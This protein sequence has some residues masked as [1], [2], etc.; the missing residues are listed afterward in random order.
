MIGETVTDMR[1]GFD[2]LSILAQDVL[3]QDPFSGA[4]FCFRGRRGDLVKI[5][6]LDGQG[7]CLFAKR[8]EKSRFTW[9]AT[10]DPQDEMLPIPLPPC[11]H[12]E[13]VW[14]RLTTQ[15]LSPQHS[16]ARAGS[17][18]GPSRTSPPTLGQARSW[19]VSGA[20]S[21]VT[22]DCY[23]APRC[24]PALPCNHRPPP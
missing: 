23:D 10:L 5:L 18:S 7:F 14:P 17:F 8:L 11:S 16:P 3:K 22:F 1:K 13:A 19:G 15:S 21:R 9:P 24:T 2:G 4:I 6:Y 20:T 12:F